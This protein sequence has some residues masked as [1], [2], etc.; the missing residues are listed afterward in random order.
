MSWLIPSAVSGLFYS[1]AA[2]PKQRKSI[3]AVSYQEKQLE[4]SE[5]RVDNLT[6]QIQ[7]KKESFAEEIEQ[8]DYNIKDAKSKI[9]RDGGDDTNFAINNYNRTKDNLKIKHRDELNKL[10]ALLHGAQMMVNSEQRKLKKVKLA[11]EKA[12]EEAMRW[13]AADAKARN[14]QRLA[15]AAAKAKAMKRRAEIA[16]HP[17]DSDDDMSGGRKK[18]SKTKRTNKKK[19]NKKMKKR[20]TKKHGKSKRR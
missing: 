5:N 11:E 10:D 12:N 20:S 14:E 17:M 9:L 1:N 15:A 4:E 8:I 3:E 6:K 19:T 16:P 7:T 18:H 2:P 13:A